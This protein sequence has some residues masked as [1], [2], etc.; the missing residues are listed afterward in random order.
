MASQNSR[1]APARGTNYFGDP[2][3]GAYSA[4]FYR[5]PGGVIWYWTGPENPARR[6]EV[7]MR[8]GVSE[9]YLQQQRAQGRAGATLASVPGARCAECGIDARGIVNAYGP[10][11][12]QSIVLKQDGVHE[13]S[14]CYLTGGGR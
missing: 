5:A 12:G 1:R 2:M 3:P 9:A 6:H 7:T 14:D 11:S 4:L 13:C 8:H 10:N